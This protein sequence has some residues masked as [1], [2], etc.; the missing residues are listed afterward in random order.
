M[1]LAR[2]CIL[3]KHSYFC[4]SECVTSLN[5][6]NFKFIEFPTNLEIVFS[7]R[8]ENCSYIYICIYIYIPIFISYSS[9][10]K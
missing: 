1:L 8:T 10:D 9:V 7:F 4:F 6:I 5:I 2:L 3:E